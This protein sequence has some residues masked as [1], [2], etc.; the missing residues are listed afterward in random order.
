LDIIL[1]YVDSL[2]FLYQLVYLL[3]RLGQVV[4]YIVVERAERRYIQA[5]YLLLQLALDA[6]IKELAYYGKEDIVFPDP[7][8]AVMSTFLFSLMNLNAYFCG[9]V[10]SSKFLVN[11]S[12]TYSLSTDRLSLSSKGFPAYVIMAINI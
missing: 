6:V 11:H 9:G 4:V 8:G 10:S 5:V 12:R 2:L 1:Y 7:V 3:Q